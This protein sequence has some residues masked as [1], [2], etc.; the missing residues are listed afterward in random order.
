MF[1]T[2]NGMREAS[3]QVAVLIT[4][5]QNNGANFEHLRNDFQARI[6]KI[7]VVGVGSSVQEGE[8][9]ELVDSQ[10]D[11]F[12]HVENFSKLDINDFIK[13]TKICRKM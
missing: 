11:D 6:I 10:D 5:G 3:P 8:L 1:Q 13:K 9:R 12:L 2:G 4:D 7:L